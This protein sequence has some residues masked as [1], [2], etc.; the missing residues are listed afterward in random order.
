MRRV[1]SLLLGLAA[2]YA[3]LVGA[4]Y[5]GQRKLLYPAFGPAL[6]AAEAGLP[7]FED[8]VLATPDGERLAAWYR[9]P[10]PGRATVLY[11]HGNGGSLSLRRGR[12]RLLAEGGRG[13]LMVTYRGYPGS[14]GQPTE[15][16]LA[17]DALTAHRWLGERVPAE[18]V[19][20]YGESLGTGVAV[21]LAAEQRFGGVIL[22]APFT[23][24]ADVA[25]GVFPFLP[26]R[27]LMRDQYRSEARIG[28]LRA[29]LLV[30]HGDRDGVVPFALGE[31]LF[32][33]APEPKRLVRIAGGDH[34][35]NLEAGLA[36]VRAF[37]AE[38][39]A[40]FARP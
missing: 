23:S 27:L 16:G 13:L 18:R 36:E 37:L 40:R 38:A 29:P 8:V 35:G 1:L 32:R 15:A 14:T 2:L 39:E 19:V 22:D 9:A 7:G 12:A 28:R 24:T 20:L 5:L 26:V 25:A 10:E 34:V 6:A 30:L 3:V 31:R 21:G 17:L 4:A 11:F 33:A